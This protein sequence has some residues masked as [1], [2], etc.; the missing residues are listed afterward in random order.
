MYEGCVDSPF[1]FNKEQE[2]LM[3]V[4][5]PST[6]VQSRFWESA[7]MSIGLNTVLCFWHSSFSLIGAEYLEYLTPQQRESRESLDTFDIVLLC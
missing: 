2:S 6:R 5:F 7:R 1:R 3:L 4:N